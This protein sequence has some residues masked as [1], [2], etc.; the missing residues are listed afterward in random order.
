MLRERAKVINLCGATSGG[1]REGD[2]V[3]CC[4]SVLHVAV[5]V[6]HVG[7]CVG[8]VALVGNAFDTFSCVCACMHALMHAIDEQWT[9]THAAAD[10]NNNNN[11]NNNARHH[12]TNSCGCVDC[13]VMGV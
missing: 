4:T 1:M 8:C 10:N 12:K 7:C 3:Q 9:T 13:I 2:R 5:V 6:L 11:N